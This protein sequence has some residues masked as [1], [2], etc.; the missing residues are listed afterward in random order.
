MS[1]KASPFVVKFDLSR[2]HAG[3]TE[4]E[5]APAAAERA[6][7]ARWLEVESIDV[8][9][10]VV[11][12]KKLATDNFRYEARFTADVTQSCVVTLVPVRSHIE[13]DFTRAFQIGGAQHVAT[14]KRVV[15]LPSV[16]EDDEPEILE[17]STLDIAGPVVEELALA[18]DPYPRAPGV[19]FQTPEGVGEEKAAGENPFTVLKALKPKR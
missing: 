7:L 5:L 2:L 18:I 13:R 11:R 3:E 14:A 4:I 15:Q 1:E 19:V 8:L 12:L 17:S 16:G 6:A 9:E 10:G